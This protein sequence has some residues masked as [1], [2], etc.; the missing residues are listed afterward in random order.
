MAAEDDLITAHRWARHW[1]HCSKSATFL[2]LVH[3]AAPL[4]PS[5]SVCTNIPHPVCLLACLRRCPLPPW[6]PAIR[7]QH[8]EESMGSVREEMNLLSDL[9]GSSSGGE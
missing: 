4:L 7:R 9:D 2:P 1:Q 5:T 6:P 3:S 8:I